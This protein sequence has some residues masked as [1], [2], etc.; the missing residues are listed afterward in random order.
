M[1]FFMNKLH[2]NQQLTKLLFFLRDL[3]PART[4]E[5]VDLTADMSYGMT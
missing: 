4:E 1:K 2:D 5:L 3:F